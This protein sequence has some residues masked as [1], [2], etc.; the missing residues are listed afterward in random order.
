MK[1]TVQRSGGVAAITR[2]WTVDAATSEARRR[3]MPIVEACPWDQVPSR[4]Q[5]KGATAQAA[6]KAAGQ[7][8]RFMYSIRAGQ[9]RATLPETDVTGPWHTLVENAKVEGRETLRR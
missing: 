2:V 7:A 9:H 5:A 8:D 1:I 3:W 4:G 6:G